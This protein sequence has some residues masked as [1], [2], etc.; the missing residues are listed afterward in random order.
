MPLQGAEN[1]IK[2][3]KP[4]LVICVYHKPE[5][6]IEL[7]RLIKERRQLK[8]WSPLTNFICEGII[9]G[10]MIRYCMQFRGCQLRGGNGKWGFSYL[11]QN[12]RLM[13]V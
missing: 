8:K 3:K 11:K 9:K 2:E 7:P 4:I 1:F 5:D 13:S 10:F 12:M 6:I